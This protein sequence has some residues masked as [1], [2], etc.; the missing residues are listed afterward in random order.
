MTDY[1]TKCI[2][3]DSILE[4]NGRRI[5]CPNKSCQ[6]KYEREFAEE[7]ERIHKSNK[8]LEKEDGLKI[9]KT[10]PMGCGTSKDKRKFEK[11]KIGRV[12]ITY[13]CTACGNPETVSVRWRSH[14]A[15]PN[16]WRCRDIIPTNELPR[17]TDHMFSCSKKCRQAL[18]NLY[19]PPV[20]PKW[21]ATS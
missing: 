10:I 9:G 12:D 17:R 7:M 4:F 21:F 8:S 20:K 6:E 16:G 11:V 3:C 15:L 14:H 1:S 5:A 13:F 19:P 18:D 2:E